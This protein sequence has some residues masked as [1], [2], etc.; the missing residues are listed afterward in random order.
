MYIDRSLREYL[1]DL[2]A[3]IPAP[4]GGSAAALIAAAGVSLMSMA[5]NY[6]AGNPKY[7]DSEA[8]IGEMLHKLEVHGLALRGFID[9]DVEAYAGLRNILKDKTVSPEVLDSA[10][11]ESLE[12][13]FG[14]CKITAECL[15]LCAE[16]AGRGNPNLITDTAIAAIFLE[17]AFFSAK[18]NVYLNMKHIRDMDFIG[19]L[20]GV[21]A[22]L[23]EEMPRLKEEILEM[24]EDVIGK[25]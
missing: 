13:P 10:Y 24:C 4:G 18:F 1:D 20:H 17:G 25:D 15:K 7:K 11:K 6:T 19:A 3:R 23:E 2:A 22:P 16:L 14:V 8:V 5:A 21:L 12:P 9:K